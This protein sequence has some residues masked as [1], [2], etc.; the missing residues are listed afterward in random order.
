MGSAATCRE[1][2]KEGLEEGR[3]ESL[4]ARET[5]FR[6]LVPGDLVGFVHWWLHNIFHP[7]ENM[8]QFCRTKRFQ[9]VKCSY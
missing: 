5:F 9:M 1:M 6:S 2:E 8:C 4:T 3:G 7:Q